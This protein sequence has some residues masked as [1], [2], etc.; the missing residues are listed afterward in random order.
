MN[1]NLNLAIK[2]EGQ[3]GKDLS[4]YPTKLSRGLIKL[5]L[6]ARVVANKQGL[7]SYKREVLCE[8]IAAITELKYDGLNHDYQLSRMKIHSSDRILYAIDTYFYRHVKNLESEDELEMQLSEDERIK[9][10][11]YAELLTLLK[12]QQMLELEEIVD[13]VKLNEVSDRINFLRGQ[14]SSKE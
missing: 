12:E 8:I 11:V 1:S 10:P 2:K 4:T 14:I 13:T 9:V 6:L 3:Q 5:I 7:S